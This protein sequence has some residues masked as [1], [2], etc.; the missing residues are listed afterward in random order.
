ML[1]E[2]IGSF[3]EYTDPKDSRK[4]NLLIEQEYGDFSFKVYHLESKEEIPSKLLKNVKKFVEQLDA[5]GLDYFYGLFTDE[6]KD[7]I[8]FHNRVLNAFNEWYN[9]KI[10]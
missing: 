10:R 4:V 8:C 5:L 3:E 9:S 2:E 6:D 1:E 7:Y